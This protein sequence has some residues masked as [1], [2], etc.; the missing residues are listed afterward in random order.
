[1]SAWW[2]GLGRTQ[3]AVALVLGLVVAVNVSL[4][5][6]GSLVGGDDPGGPVSSSTSTG[7]SGLEAYADLLA[8]A[9][10]P[11]TR[12]GSVATDGD[13]DPGATAVLADPSSLSRAEGLAVLR[14]VDAGG[15]L[16]VAGEAATPLVEALA[17]APV[18]WTAGEPVEGL[19]VWLPVAGTGGART[20]AGDAGGRWIGSG[21]LLPVAGDREAGPDGGSAVLAGDAGAGSGQVVA[22]ADASLLH[23]DAL[24]RADNA[25]LGLAAAGDPFRPVVFLESSRRTTGGLAAVPPSWKWAAAGLGLALLLGLWAAG[26]RFGPPEPTRRALR[27]PRRD[28]VDAVAANLAALGGPPAGTA[29]PGGPGDTADQ[30]DP[31]PTPS[32]GARP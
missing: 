1:M 7:G 22:L 23:N 21:V 5:S 31:A 12:L 4:A 28:H 32:P 24:G 19:A 30:L 13:L 15:R 18:S 25:E 20:L 2:A 26:A 9:G 10:H 27:P 3:R 8:G 17:G 29:P 11:V 14:F 6:L 16:V